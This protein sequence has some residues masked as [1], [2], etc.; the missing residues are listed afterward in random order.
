MLIKILLFSVPILL[1]VACDSKPEPSVELPDVQSQGELPKQLKKNIGQK[2]IGEYRLAQGSD[3][4]KSIR[5][6]D[7]DYTQEELTCT[8]FTADFNNDGRPLSP[9]QRLNC[10]ER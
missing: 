1:L 2:N 3:F 5:S 9:N 8:I 4:V 10:G 6:F 7:K